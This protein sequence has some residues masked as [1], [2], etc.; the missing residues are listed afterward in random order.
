MRRFLQLAL[1][2]SFAFVAGSAANAATLTL[3]DLVNGATFQSDNGLL[4]F[5]DFEVTRLKR[6]NANLAE[7]TITTTTDGFILTSPHLT[8]NTGGLK[9]LDLTYKVAA[10]QGTITGA[11]MAMEGTR[12]TGRIKV[13]KDIESPDGD[14]GTFLLTL[15]RNNASLLTDSDTFDPGETSFEVEE[16]IRIKKI[17]ALT[18][19][20]NA[21]TV[22]VSEPA[23]AA[24]LLAGLAGLAF[25]GRR[26]RASA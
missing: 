20:R 24:L 5:S 22:T 7:Y 11:S 1:A 9:K 15:L 19:L 16:T 3:Q 4:T 14:E 26:S 8:A 10:V 6:L 12:Q 13:E 25:Y 2:L 23:E 21:Y 18:S 17:S